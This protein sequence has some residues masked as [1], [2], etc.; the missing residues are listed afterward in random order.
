MHKTYIFFFP[1]LSLFLSTLMDFYFLKTVEPGHGKKNYKSEEVSPET[2]I[3]N[4]S[5]IFGGPYTHVELRCREMMT[6]PYSKLCL[7]RKFKHIFSVF[8]Q[9]YTYFHALFHHTYFQKN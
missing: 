7:V 3:W 1:A 6:T 9:Q 5:P 4:T 2:N 8:K